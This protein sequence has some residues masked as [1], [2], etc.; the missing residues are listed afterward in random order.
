MSYEFTEQDVDAASKK[1]INDL[2]AEGRFFSSP[3]TAF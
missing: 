1:I 2:L 3:K